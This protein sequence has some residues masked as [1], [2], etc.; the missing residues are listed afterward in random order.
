MAGF[1]GAPVGKGQKLWAEGFLLTCRLHSEIGGLLPQRIGGG[2]AAHCPLTSELTSALL[3]FEAVRFASLLKFSRK[4]PAGFI[5]RIFFWGMHPK[6]LLD[7]TFIYLFA[8]GTTTVVV[9]PCRVAL[10]FKVR[11]KWDP[12][13]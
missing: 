1:P 3:R 6:S 13:L 7:W 10:R 12:L 5:V 8:C 2:L 4:D 11:S 9:V